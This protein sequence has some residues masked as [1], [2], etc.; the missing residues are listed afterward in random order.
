MIRISSRCFSVSSMIERHFY[1]S[2]ELDNTRDHFP[3]RHGPELR[4][5]DLAQAEAYR[6]LNR[7]PLPGRPRQG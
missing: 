3:S 5:T 6:Q 4:G 2:S 7:R 1:A